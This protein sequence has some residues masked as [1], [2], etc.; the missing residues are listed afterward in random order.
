MYEK[1]D[2]G[3][4][5]KEYKKKTIK[6]LREEMTKRNIG[7]MSGWSKMVLIKRLMEEDKKGKYQPDAQLEQFKIMFK[8]LE[9]E[10][11][12]LQRDFNELGDKQTRLL[13]LNNEYAKQKASIKE[14]MK[15]IEANKKFLNT[16]RQSIIDDL[17]PD[18]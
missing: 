14:R 5:I 16:Q 18:W 3:L 2:S 4:Q 1:S 11:E 6:Q 9:L 12:E 7:Y 10:Y 8:S 17:D 15:D 13:E